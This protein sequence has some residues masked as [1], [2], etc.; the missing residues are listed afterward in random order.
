MAKYIV[1]VELYGNASWETYDALHAAMEASFFYRNI[2][3]DDGRWWQL[4]NA[5][6][7]AKGMITL[8]NVRT[9]VHAIASAIWQDCAVFVTEYEAAAWIGLRPASGPTS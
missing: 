8:V 1:R 2:Q 9:K 3:S 7:Q 5:E 4:P 6:Y